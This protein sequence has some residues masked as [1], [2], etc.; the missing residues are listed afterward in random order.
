MKLQLALLYSNISCPNTGSS[1]VSSPGPANIQLIS[2]KL[3]S[4]YFIPL[5][6]HFLCIRM[7]P[8]QIIESQVYQ[9]II[10]VLL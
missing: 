1:L 4:R 9:S 10:A 5:S 3:I 7:T 6:L 2:T 8:S